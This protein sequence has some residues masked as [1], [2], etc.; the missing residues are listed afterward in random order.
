MSNIQSFQSVAKKEELIYED[1]I[2]LGDIYED[3]IVDSNKLTVGG[4]TFK[5]STQFSKYATINIHQ[6]NLRCHEAKIALLDCGEIHATT[7]DIGTVSSG[8]VRAQ[9]IT[10]EHLKGDSSIYAS[11]SIRIGKISG[12]NNK[13]FINYKEVPI[14]TSKI[15]LIEDDIEELTIALGKVQENYSSL[16]SEIASEITRLNEEIR[17]IQNSTKNAKI[18]IKE[19]V[20]T[21]NTISFVIDDANTLTFETKQAT[22]A[23]FYLSFSENTIT[24]NS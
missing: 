6:G 15:T 11:S 22:Y 3:S 5:G 13:L 8:L 9:D 10:I 18:T 16:E 14:L 17:N 4:K 19:E 7:V 21:K 24:L 23:P 1:L 20:K 12:E 2:I